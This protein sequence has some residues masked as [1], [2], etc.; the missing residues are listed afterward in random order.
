[1]SITRVTGR[2]GLIDAIA[3]GEKPRDAWRVGTEYECFAVDR[4]GLRPLP[5]QA[6]K[7]PSIH[8]ILTSFG[9]RTGWEPMLDAGALIGLK[10]PGGASITLEPA[11]QVEMSGAPHAAIADTAAELRHFIN[12]L[13]DLGDDLGVRWLWVGHLPVGKPSDLGFVPKRR[14]DIMRRYLPTRG[15]LALHMMQTTCTV[16]SNIDFESE[17]DMGRKLRTAM[18]ISSLLTAMFA[19][20]PFSEGKDSGRQ[21]FRQHIWT[22]VDPD[23]SGLLRWVFDDELPTYERYVEYA[24]D[25]P[26]FFIARD[27][28]Y[29]DCAGLPFRQLMDK[30]YEGHGATLGD[31]E[32]H[33][34]TLFPDVRLKTY[35]ELRAA[36]CVPPR[37]ICALPALTKGWLYEPTALDAAWDLTK[38]WSFDE[39][40]QHR[41]D[42]A[43]LGLRARAPGGHVTSDLVNELLRIARYGLDTLGPDA[44]EWQYVEPLANLLVTGRNLADEALAWA[45]R[46]QP[47]DRDL[48]QHYV[49]I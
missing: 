32:T 48:I 26:L 27:G 4:G 47:G 3:A 7:G 23:R 25:V 2:D 30:G 16:Q 17:G 11:G 38:R 8:R 12:D 29:L 33:L 37:F 1:M 6:A 10:G 22:R 43:K 45:Q 15:D 13:E 20:S 42:S 44:N 36:D 46:A 31:W 21:S 40:Q 49:A 14:Y 5:Y 9:E 18:G 41:V 34:S 24:L 39:R 28:A 19:N 35:L